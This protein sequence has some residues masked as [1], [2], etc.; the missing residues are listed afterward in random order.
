MTGNVI[1]PITNGKMSGDRITFSAGGTQY[2][3][4]VAGNAIDGASK[5]D[6]GEAKWQATRAAK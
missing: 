3:G 4:T 5:A 1:A 6:G 2:T